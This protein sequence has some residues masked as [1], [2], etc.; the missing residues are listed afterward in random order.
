MIVAFST[1]ACPDWTLDR[2]ARIA[3]EL[4]YD[5]VELRTLGFGDSGLVCDPAMTDPV[6]VHTT[7]GDQGVRPV[8]LATSL[9][10]DR[11]IWPPVLGRAITDQERETRQAKR[12]IDLA[13]KMDCPNLRV[14]AFE[15][16]G[17][18]SRKS[19][20]RRIVW[21][22]GAAVDAARNTGVRLVLENGGGFARGTDLAE[23]IDQ[24]Q[25]AAIGACYSVAVGR[26]AGED[27]VAGM[28]ALGDR[29]AVVRLKGH[30]G[31][32]ACLLADGDDPNAEVVRA[33]A[34]RRFQGVLVY[35]HDL[36]WQEASA[37]ESMP[38]T[39]EALAHAIESIYSW[40]DVRRGGR[41]V[42]AGQGHAVHA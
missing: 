39:E 5:G 3:G 10:F 17:R 31:G 40:R 38:R 23:V 6:K 29:L 30:R 19:A 11:I 2:V 37:R 1:L 15:P 26:H 22:L 16:Q 8:C 9:K 41:A 13:A 24:V 14:Y 34:A 33:L 35:E 4:A 36:L 7:L 18:E 42:G 21:R 32:R 12:L 27:P 20:V 28:D 25:G